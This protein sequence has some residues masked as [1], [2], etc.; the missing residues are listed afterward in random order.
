MKR[1]GFV[2]VL[3]LCLSAGL[4]ADGMRD[5]FTVSLDVELARVTTNEALYS[6][7]A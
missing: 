5:G 7:G 3:G 1:C 2:L 6:F 4:R